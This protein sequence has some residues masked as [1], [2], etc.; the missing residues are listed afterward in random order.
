MVLDRMLYFCAAKFDIHVMITHITGPNNDI[1]NILSRFQ[2]AC[3][4][5]LAPLAEPQPDTILAW[6]TQFWT[7]SSMNIN[8]Q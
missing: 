7:N 1:A 5:Q 4:H 2:T 3:F 6:P 8:L